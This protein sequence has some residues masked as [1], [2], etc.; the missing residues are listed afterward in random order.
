MI[1]LDQTEWGAIPC[2]SRIIRICKEMESSNR[3]YHHLQTSWI[4]IHLQE[5]QI[6]HPPSIEEWFAMGGCCSSME[7]TQFHPQRLTVFPPFH[8][9]LSN[10]FLLA[11]GPSQ[12]TKRSRK[13]NGYWMNRSNSRKFFS[14]FAQSKG[15]DPLDFQ[16]WNQYFA[17]DVIQHQ[18]CCYSPQWVETSHH[19]S[20]ETPPPR[21]NSIFMPN[22]ELL[23]P[24]N[25]M[26]DHYRRLSWIPFLNSKVQPLFF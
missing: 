8:L 4:F 6:P 22:R 16:Q 7:G 23:D 13:P 9:P 11:V 24:W 17:A 18:V 10:I 14:E 21:T 5:T 20:Y 19:L 2:N 3:R 25:S 15:F 12:S 26:E 1:T